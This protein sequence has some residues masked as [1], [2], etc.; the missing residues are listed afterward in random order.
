M[1]EDMSKVIVE[2]P[3]LGS[4]RRGARRFR[5]LDPKRIALGE[6]VDDPFPDRIGHK[7]A[8][9][10]AR[11]RKSLNENLAPLRR[12]LA[13]QVGRP[14]DQ[15][16]SEIC[17]NIRLDNAVQKHVRDHIDDF[18]AS[19]TLLKD[20]VIHVVDRWSQLVPL[21]RL[22]RMDLY[23]HPTTGLLRRTDWRRTDRARR[24]RERAAEQREL[25]ARLRVIDENR[26]LHLLDDGNWWEVT[27]ASAWRR[28]PGAAYP[29]A[30]ADIVD[31]VER[32]CLSSLPREQR[33]NRGGV[34][35]VAKRALSR[36]E[37]KA[38]GLRR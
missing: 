2:R 34:F 10:L 30:D 12:Y 7:L 21:S 20:G 17:S 27:L 19:T 26:Q 13:K 38:L 32:A 14:W 3:R 36:K 31:V 1:R 33:Y 22:E 18:V 5:R 25:A 35:A 37:I 23:V 8:A 29:V 16:F 4:S 6:D 9:S 11:R 24:R 15:V 28:P